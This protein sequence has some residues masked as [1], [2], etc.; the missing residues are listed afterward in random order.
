MWEATC[1]VPSTWEIT[2]I[3][4][5]SPTPLINIKILV[6][7]YFFRI[8]RL[9]NHWVFGSSTMAM[10]LNLSVTLSLGLNP[11]PKFNSKK[12]HAYGCRRGLHVSCSSLV[13]EQQ[14]SISFSK[15][16]THLI[17]ALIGIQGRGKSA[18]PQ[19]LQVNFYY[20]VI[21]VIYLDVIRGW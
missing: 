9:Q 10:K 18:S 15:P 8:E 19:Q 1:H 4:A 17:D 13:E 3:S 11:F 5:L 21:C 7:F 6:M 12:L 16:E 2:H 20:Y 14:Q